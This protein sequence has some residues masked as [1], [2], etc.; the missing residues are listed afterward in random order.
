M[1]PEIR[2]EGFQPNEV[3]SRDVELKLREFSE[4]CAEGSYILAVFSFKEEKYEADISVRYRDGQIAVKSEGPEFHSVLK[5]SLNRLFEQLRLWRERRFVEP[6]QLEKDAESD[7]Y[8]ELSAGTQRWTDKHP[9]VLIVDDDPG[10]VTLLD[11]IFRKA[12]CETKI[13]SDAYKAVNEMST[14]RYGLIVLDWFLPY[15][16]GGEVIQE[17]EKA[18]VDSG[19]GRDKPVPVITCSGMHKEKINLPQ[20]EHFKF[21]DHWDKALPFS[22]IMNHAAQLIPAIEKQ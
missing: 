12:G 13:V 5:D 18:W 14:N 1:T 10:S 19:S 16:D 4:F 17:A 22:S 3:D 9:H 20:T 11:T 15:M 8:S 7:S 6:F 2:Y 21:I